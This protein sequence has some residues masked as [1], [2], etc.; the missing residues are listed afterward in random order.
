MG[1][2]PIPRTNFIFILKVVFPYMYTD[3][4]GKKVQRLVLILE[5]MNIFDIYYR[6]RVKVQ[7][8]NGGGPM[9]DKN[10]KCYIW[11]KI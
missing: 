5:I 11:I 8:R 1:S 7:T 4:Q 9:I 3:A 2:S 6:R 10:G